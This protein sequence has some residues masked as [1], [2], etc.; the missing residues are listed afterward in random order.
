MNSVITIDGPSGAGKSTV[1]RRLANVLEFRYID[2]GALYRIAALEVMDRHIEEP[3]DE[4][5][6]E[7]CRNLDVVF[8]NGKEQNRIFSHNKDVTEMIR[9]PEIS[10]LASQLS[11]RPVTRECLTSLQRGMADNMNIVLEGRDAGTVVFPDA[12]VKF[13]LD[14]SP[15]ERGKRRFKEL[16][17]K[18]SSVSL[19]QVTQEIIKRDQNDTSRQFAPL[20]P[21]ADALIIDSTTMSI[22]EVVDRMIQEIKLKK[23]EGV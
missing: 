5:L 8:S 4:I 2:S 22:D 13:F 21:A 16:S 6:A 12:L 15:E 11:A 19:E 7:I 20:R 9:S 10:M 3:S 23:I 1:S 18:G 17:L 14:A